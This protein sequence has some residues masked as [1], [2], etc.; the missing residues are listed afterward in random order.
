M[1]NIVSEQET[2][3]APTLE[4]H[5]TSGVSPDEIETLLDMAASCGLFNADELTSIEDMAYS[6]AYQNDDKSCRFFLAKSVESGKEQPVGFIC[7]GTIPD[8]PLDHEL[9]GISVMQ[10]FQ[11]LGIGS[12]LLAEMERHVAARGGERIFVEIPTDDDDDEIRDFYETNGFVEENR[13]R[14]QFVPKEGGLVFRLDVLENE[15]QSNQ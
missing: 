4:V 5:I 1:N 6:C 10:E 8:W 2:Q 3:A 7:F 9:Y 12:A 15:D 11:R 14:K 13:Y